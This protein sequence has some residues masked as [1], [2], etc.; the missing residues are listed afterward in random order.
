MKTWGETFRHFSMVGQLGLTLA[1]PLLLCVLVCAW[2]QNKFGV[3]GWVYILGFLFGLGGSAT[4]AWK[5][6]CSVTAQTKK[7]RDERGKR[8][9][10]NRHI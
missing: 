9:A 10:F 8:A 7:E 5:L 6:Y 3:G 4:S 2:L 1:M